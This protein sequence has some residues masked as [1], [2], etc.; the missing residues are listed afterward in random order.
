MRAMVGEQPGYQVI[1]R[2]AG[3]GIEKM[4]EVLAEFGL[5]FTRSAHP[6]FKRS[7][8]GV[9]CLD[10][11]VGPLVESRLVLKRDPEELADCGHRQ[12]V[13][14]VFDNVGAAMIR[15]LVDQAS[16][17]IGEPGPH[18]V[19]PSGCAGWPEWTHR[20]FPEPV[21]V[22]RVVVNK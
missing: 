6:L 3:P 16:G 10:E 12:R 21:M 17:D 20:Q 8:G 13:G 5:D 9:E 7:G 11:R 4:T 14:K 22:G 2:L 1:A 15:E 19:N 18:S